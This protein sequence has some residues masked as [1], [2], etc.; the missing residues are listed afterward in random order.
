[1]RCVYVCIGLLMVLIC[2][3]FPALATVVLLAQLRSVRWML[4]LLC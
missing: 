3:L 2:L 4:R 1:M